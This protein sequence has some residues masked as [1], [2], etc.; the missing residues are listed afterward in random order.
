MLHAIANCPLAQPLSLVACLSAT[1]GPLAPARVPRRE[2][3][4]VL[5]TSRS[6]RRVGQVHAAVELDLPVSLATVLLL[7]ADPLVRAWSSE[8][9]QFRRSAWA[10]IEPIVQAAIA[11]CNCQFDGP[12]R[13]PVATGGARAS[14]VPSRVKYRTSR[15]AYRRREQILSFKL[16]WTSYDVD[17]VLVRFTVYETSLVKFLKVVAR[18]RERPWPWSCSWRLAVA[19]SGGHWHMAMAEY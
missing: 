3:P 17:L 9:R 18:L 15:C 13:G 4:Q 14:H 16:P 5:S 8:S 19:G 6:T 1:L 7:G 11:H 10:S 2:V 12:R